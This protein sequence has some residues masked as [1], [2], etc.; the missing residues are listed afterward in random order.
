MIDFSSKTYRNIL[1][2][3]LSQIPNTFDKRDTSPIQTALGPAAYALEE[4]YLNLNSVQQS[5]FVSSAQGEDLDELAV[6]GGITRYAASAAVRLGTFNT[7]VP[8]GSR[9]STI[10]GGVRSTSLSLRNT[11]TDGIHLRAIRIG[12]PQKRLGL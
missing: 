7:A 1:E 8:L 5:A 12:S 4:F 6:I 9:F 11:R 10:N 2:Q 3:M